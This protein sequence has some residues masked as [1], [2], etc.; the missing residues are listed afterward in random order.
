MEFRDGLSLSVGLRLCAASDIL[1]LPPYRVVALEGELRTNASD[2]TAAWQGY[3][4]YVG[5]I[6]AEH[7]ISNGGPIIAVQVGE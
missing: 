3:M 6:T 5:K 1:S 4:D 7:Q 2:Y